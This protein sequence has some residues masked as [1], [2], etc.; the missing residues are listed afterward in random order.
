MLSA[1]TWPVKS[2]EMAVL[3][4]TMLSFLAMQYGFVTVS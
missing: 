1:H 2:M 3:M 4:E